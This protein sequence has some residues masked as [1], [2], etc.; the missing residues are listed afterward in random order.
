M[1][2]IKSSQVHDLAHEAIV[3]DL[4]DLKQQAQRMRVRAQ[5]EADQILAA[6]RTR[7]VELADEAQRSGHEKGF[8]EGKAEGLAEGHRTGHAEALS[9]SSDAIAQLQQR[10]SQAADEWDAS[11][12]EV[13]RD[14]Q[15]STLKLACMLAER[16]VRRV[17]QVDESVVVDQVNAAI[18]HVIGPVRVTVRVHPQ[19]RP[20]ME[21]ALPEVVHRLGT[22]SHVDLIED[23]TIE[24]GGCIVEH[25]S[26][27]IDATL[28]TQLDRLTTALLPGGKEDL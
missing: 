8:A 21:D 7:A 13:E 16:I 18:E 9:Q 24:R 1:A 10:W 2:L 15:E 28:A 25:G 23:E 6:A 4:G 19:D 22:S 11:R 17:P 5:Q 12:Q 3:L 20:L 14:A 26:G 27:R